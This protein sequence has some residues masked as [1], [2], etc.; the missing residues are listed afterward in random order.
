MDVPPS[1]SA[2]RPLAPATQRLMAPLFPDLD[3]TGVR[4]WVPAGGLA[5]MAVRALLAPHRAHALT[6]GR[7]VVARPDAL[8]VD[9]PAGLALLVHELTH[10]SQYQALGV[11]GFLGRYLG[12]YLR[13]RLRGRRHADA[14]RGISLERAAFS[15]VKTAATVLDPGAA[16]RTPGTRPRPSTR[17]VAPS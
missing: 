2:P 6:L 14:Y 3:L 11:A 16:I 15:A 9:T 1:S 10:V 12:E 7:L 5:L 8:A 13:G 4:L 17:P